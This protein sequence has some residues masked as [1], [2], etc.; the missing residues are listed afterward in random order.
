LFCVSFS[1]FIIVIFF[2]LHSSSKNFMLMCLCSCYTCGLLA[3]KKFNVWQSSSSWVSCFL[4]HLQ[5]FHIVASLARVVILVLFEL[6]FVVMVVFMMLVFLV[7]VSAHDGDGGCSGLV[8]LWWSWSSSSWHSYC[9][10]SCNG[11]HFCDV[12]VTLFLGMVI[13]FMILLLLPM[14]WWLLFF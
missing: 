13:I 10:P 1:L 8:S 6:T 12:L 9:C 5:C 7:V 11:H 4:T 2:L 14:L 3:K